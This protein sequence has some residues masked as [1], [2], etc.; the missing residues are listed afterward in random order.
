MLKVY[1]HICWKYVC[2]CSKY[3]CIYIWNIFAC[4]KYICKKCWKYI[5]IYVESIFAYMLKIC[6]S[7]L[8][9]YTSGSRQ[10]CAERSQIKMLQFPFWI[11]SKILPYHIM[12]VYIFLLCKFRANSIVLIVKNTRTSSQHSSY[13]WQSMFIIPYLAISKEKQIN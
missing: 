7:A 13:F 6:L 3:I 12:Y 5:C 1:L 11:F 9:V 10:Y 4:L 2:I 8:L